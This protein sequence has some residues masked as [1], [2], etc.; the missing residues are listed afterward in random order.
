MKRFKLIAI[1]SFISFNCHAQDLI[2]NGTFE[3]INICTEF[4][5]LCSPEAWRLT[6]PFLPGYYKNAQNNCVDF[7]VYN[8][9]VPNVRSYLE[10]RLGDTLITGEK[11]RL[12]MDVAPDELMINSIGVLFS[13][14]L[15]HTQSNVLLTLQPDIEFVNNKRLLQYKRG[16]QWLHL[17]KEFVADHKALFIIIGN[18]YPDKSLIKKEIRKKIKAYNTCKYYIDNV[19]LKPVNSIYKLE[20]IHNV[21]NIIYSMDQRHP[22]SDTLFDV[23][24]KSV[25]IE[26]KPVRNSIVKEDTIL[27]YDDLLFAF[28][29]YEPS[30]YFRGKVDSLLKNLKN[31][32]DSLIVVGNTDNIGSDL[33]NLKLSFKRAQ[34][35]ANYITTKGIIPK[36]R[37][38]YYGEGSKF[39]IA[40]NSTASGRYKN[41]RVEIIIKYQ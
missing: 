5:A 8:S 20:D 25:N 29:S 16:K 38:I 17:E 36:N 4:I 9:S 37:I 26:H 24:S 14:T 2:L 39:P 30:N 27:L 12:S 31:P 15:I 35:V 33:Y 10:S 11:Y 21:K 23:R 22:V 7:I 13:D 34:A 6:S 19:Q 28:D 3:D 41:R 1:I 18:F 32:V 40:T